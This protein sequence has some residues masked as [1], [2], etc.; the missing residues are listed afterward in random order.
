MGSE[1]A[2]DLKS[3]IADVLSNPQN[4]AQE[5]IDALWSEVKAYMNTLPSKER[6]AFHW[7]SCAEAFYLLTTESEGADQ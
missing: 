1:K 2:V 3:K 7:E 6:G 4:F 5:D